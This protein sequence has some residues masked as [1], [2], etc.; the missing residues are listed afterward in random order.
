MTEYSLFYKKS[1]RVEAD[2]DFPL[3]DNW[4]TFISS[5]N[6]NEKI[7]E[8]FKNI[9]AKEKYWLIQPEYGFSPGELPPLVGC[10]EL[11][12]P[13]ESD[14]SV[15]ISELFDRIKIDWGN[16]NLCVDI[17]GF[18]A[19]TI[20]YFLYYLWNKKIKK[21]DVIY[22][23]AERYIRKE[24][25]DF[26]SKDI[27]EVRPVYGYEGN[28]KTKT[29]DD[30][31]IIGTGYDHRLIL[32]LVENKEKAKKIKIY[33]F[34]SLRP[35]MYQ[36]N[37]LRVHEVSESIEGIYDPDY[38][39]A[40]ANDPFE[41]ANVLKKILKNLKKYGNYP[42]IYLSPLGTKAQVLGFGF[43]YLNE[44]EDQRLPVSI[45]FPVS[46]GYEKKTSEG[47]SRVW[48]YTIEFVYQSL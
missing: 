12:I 16:V 35:D 26:Y 25:T 36:E 33:G 47:L 9:S 6:Q 21:F 13:K 31:L 24:Q 19:P 34:P 38:E 14:E 20:L 22:S 46:A 29:E 27:N 15:I 2:A 8:V 37:I 39:F 40:P 10:K 45:I 44:C 3:N 5:Y 17:S 18:L 32:S 28:H 30:A 42:N 4:D 41:T 43:F 1:Y 7:N 48:K 23:E 11:I